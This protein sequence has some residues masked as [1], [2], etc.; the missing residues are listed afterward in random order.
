MSDSKAREQF[1]AYFRETYTL[2]APPPEYGA[3]G[4]LAWGHAF[5]PSQPETYHCSEVRSAWQ[6][7]QASRATA[8]KEAEE[9]CR[10][11]ARDA[12]ENGL[13]KPFNFMDGAYHAAE[14]I[15]AIAGRGA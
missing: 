15:R 13:S 14:A 7:W 3:L 8:L 10:K 2:T 1:E 4:W 12:A 9:A 5:G 6:A 11:V